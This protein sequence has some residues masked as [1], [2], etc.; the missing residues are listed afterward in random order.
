MSS[1]KKCLI[2]GASGGI[3]SSITKKLAEKNYK[4]SIARCFTFIG[5]H[6][7]EYNYAITEIIKNFRSNSSI[8]L[9]SKVMTFLALSIEI[10]S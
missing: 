3:G 2:V 6:I 9:I 5:N 8:K 10:G 1:N 7:L 4:V